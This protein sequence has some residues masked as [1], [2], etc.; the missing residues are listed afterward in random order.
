LPSVQLRYRIT[1]DSDIRAVYGRGISR[2]NPHDVVPYVTVDQ[3]TNP[4][5]ISTGNPNLKPEHAN[6]YYILYEHYLK[7]YGEL[8]AGFVYKQLSQPIYYLADPN[9]EGAQYPQYHGLILDYIANGVNANLY[10]VEF[11]Y[12]QHLGFLPGRWSG[13]G[14]MANYSKTGSSAGTL[15]LRND[16]PALQRQTPTMWN[17]SPSYD[18]GRLSAAWAR[19][20]TVPASININGRMHRY[21]KP[22]WGMRGSCPP[23]PRRGR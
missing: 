2:P 23:G 18:R 13:F 6:D 22:T 14:I 20:T 8:Q 1:D 12:I 4:Y 11:A 19:P 3:T 7:P 9:Y 16:N 5:T 15:P 17:L 21:T 10:G